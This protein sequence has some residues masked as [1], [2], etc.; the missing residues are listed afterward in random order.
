MR[1]K[2]LVLSIFCFCLKV[3]LAAVTVGNCDSDKHP[4]STI[5]AAIA[6]APAGGVV[7][8]CPGTYAEQLQINKPLTI[9][10]IDGGP[11]IETPATGLNELPAGSGLYPQVLVNNAGGEVK[12][13]NVAVDGSDALFI[14]DGFVYDLDVV[15]PDGI[16]ADKN[17]VGVYFFNT[18]GVLDGI[19]VSNQFGSIWEPDDQPPQTIPN[20][21]SGVVFTGSPSAVVRNSTVFNV[22]LYGIYS[23]GDLTADNNIVSGGYSPHGVGIA[24]STGTITNNKITQTIGYEETAGIQGGTLVRD[25]I[26]QTA[27]Y[28]IVGAAEV[29]HNTLTNNAIGVSQAADVTDNAISG[30]PTYDNPACINNPACD[31]YPTGMPL[32]TV[33]IDLGCGPADRM[34]GNNI[35]GV[36]IG[37]ANLEAG[38]KIPRSNLLTN[39]TTTS[40]GCSQ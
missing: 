6:A 27:I 35:E 15:C 11:V 19:S 21:G 25:N 31:S 20:C 14:V 8:V 1:W 2:I 38:E 26:V 40:T 39:V 36:G 37:F 23:N 12:L 32:P 16:L 4:Y 29:R 34:R 9:Q 18:P 30:Y 13:S 3:S 24:A 17:F 22:G 5:S 7:R 10:G 28:G 33:A